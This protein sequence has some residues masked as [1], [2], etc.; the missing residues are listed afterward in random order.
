MHTFS[1]T[2][3][4]YSQKSTFFLCQITSEMKALMQRDTDAHN[5]SA[6]KQDIAAYKGSLHIQGGLLLH[7][8]ASKQQ[9]EGHFQLA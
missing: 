7:L 6:G 9:K 3:L 4:P 8:L 1:I 2:K 5:T